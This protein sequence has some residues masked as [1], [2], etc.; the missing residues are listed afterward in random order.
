M[1]QRQPEGT[2]IVEESIIHVEISKNHKTH[3]PKTLGCILCFNFWQHS[4]CKI[5]WLSFQN[6]ILS[7]GSQL[8]IYIYLY[9]YIH[10]Q[11]DDFMCLSRYELNKVGPAVI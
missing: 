9:I 5:T 8:Y 6:V 1:S 7:F 11:K 3:A 10:A 4:M 2:K